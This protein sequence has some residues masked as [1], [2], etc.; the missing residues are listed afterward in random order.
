MEGGI[1]ILIKINGATA[2]KVINTDFV[3]VRKIGV[4]RVGIGIDRQRWGRMEGYLLS[5]H[6]RKHYI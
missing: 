4:F 5:F 1:N 3:P 6:R 2:A